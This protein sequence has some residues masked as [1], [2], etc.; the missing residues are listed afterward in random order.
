MKIDFIIIGLVAGLSGLYALFST[1][2]TLGAG[3][4]LAVMITYALLLKVK[5]TKKQE[6]TLFQNIRFKLPITIVIAGGIWV[7]A[8][9]FNFPIWWQIEFVSFALP[10]A[11]SAVKMIDPE[12]MDELVELLHNEAK[13]I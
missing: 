2:G 10:N 5:A 11:K 6:K 9:K 12:N 1:F 7:L 4:G 8:G 3:A 13:V